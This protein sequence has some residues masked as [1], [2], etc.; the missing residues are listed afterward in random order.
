[1]IFGP[2]D[3]TR[4]S[5]RPLPKINQKT[6]NFSDHLEILKHTFYNLII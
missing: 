6:L 2:C 5:E 4:A 3:G 1:M